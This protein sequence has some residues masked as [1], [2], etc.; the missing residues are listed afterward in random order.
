MLSFNI[1]PKKPNLTSFLQ[2]VFKIGTLI[3]KSVPGFTKSF[4]LG[5][6]SLLCGEVGGLVWQKGVDGEVVS[7]RL[8]VVPARTDQG[9]GV[10]P[11]EMDFTQISPIYKIKKS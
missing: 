7:Y 6:F 3:Y 10:E 8:P 9:Q 5:L 1:S 11:K 2:L 4:L